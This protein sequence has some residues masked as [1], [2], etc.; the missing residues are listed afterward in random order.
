MDTTSDE[1]PIT[2]E[3]ALAIAEADAAAVY[4]DLGRFR[5]EVSYKN[6][7]WFVN[8]RFVPRQRYRTG[9]GPSYVI[10]AFD[11]TIIWKLYGQ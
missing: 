10:N 8:Y 9:G 5:L 7:R 3:Q 6:E 1:H 4:D 2:R 11:G